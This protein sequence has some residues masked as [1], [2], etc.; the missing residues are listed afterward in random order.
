MISGPW[1]YSPD[2][3]PA[4]VIPSLKEWHQSYPESGVFALVAEGSKDK[5]PDLQEYCRQVDM[6]LVGAIFPEII[7]ASTFAKEGVLF[8][9]MDEM[10]SYIL[11]ENVGTEKHVDLLSSR[12]LNR[13]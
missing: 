4:L 13:L 5:V 3:D 10:P 12:I 7:H 2:F 1:F 6:P 8:I 9:R 11:H